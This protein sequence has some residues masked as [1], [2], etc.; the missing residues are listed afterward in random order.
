M[1]LNCLTCGACC[2]GPAGYVGCSRAD[3]ER[4]AGSV[5]VV[6]TATSR[7]L[8]M[9]PSADGLRCVALIGLPGVSVACSVYPVR[10]R[11]CRTLQPGGADCLRAHVRM[12][13][14]A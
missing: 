3:V 1:T 6:E 9:R 14:P 5:A 12:G 7:A 8:D 13:I 11:A 2:F 4:L 10:P